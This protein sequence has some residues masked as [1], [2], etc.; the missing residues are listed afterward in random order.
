MSK[1]KIN[2]YLLKVSSFIAIILSAMFFVGCDLTDRQPLTVTFIDVSGAMSADHTISIKFSEEKDYEDYY[3]DILVKSDTDNVT[4]TMFQEFAKDDD[5]V[6]INLDNDGN[7]VSL[8]EY[9]LF[10]L[11]NEQTDSMVGYG[12]V[13]STT[14]VV[15]SNKDATLTFLAVIG[16]KNNG[17][18]KQV[19]EVSKKYTLRVR[20]KVKWVWG[21]TNKK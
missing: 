1:S 13:L 18:F 19:R 12:D 9:K 7:F 17:E 11:E 2:K 4:L 5:K 10:N 20:E 8:D 15:N 6:N 16:E 3:V 14:L 21:G